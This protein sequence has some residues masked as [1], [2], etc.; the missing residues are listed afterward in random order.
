MAI[1]KKLFVVW[2]RSALADRRLNVGLGQWLL[3]YDNRRGLQKAW[4]PHREVPYVSS[5]IVASAQL[6][7]QRSWCYLGVDSR[8]N[9]GIRCRG[10]NQLHIVSPPPSATTPPLHPSSSQNHD[11]SPVRTRS[12][13]PSSANPAPMV[14]QPPGNL[15]RSLKANVQNH[16]GGRGGD[17]THNPELR[18]LV[19]YPIELLAPTSLHCSL[20]ACASI[21]PLR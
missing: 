11:L 9:G 7:W 18:R 13:G 16:C 8:E 6:F 2:L 5:A 10:V 19:L 4:C 20:A 17:R 15:P 3:A 12:Q 14:A 1:N 21:Q